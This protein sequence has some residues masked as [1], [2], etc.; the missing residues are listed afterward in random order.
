MSDAAS[1]LAVSAD[2]AAT[3]KAHEEGG[4]ASHPLVESDGAETAMTYGPNANVP[5]VV[6][7]VWICAM[8]GLGAY[9]VLYYVPDL[10]KWWR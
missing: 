8:L 3:A 4:E 9:A 6:I 10:S 5:I 2:Q 1:N 7:A